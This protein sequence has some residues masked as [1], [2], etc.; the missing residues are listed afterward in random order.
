MNKKEF[1][2]HLSNT[3]YY[4][5]TFLILKTF[6]LLKLE[7]MGMEIGFNPS[8]LLSMHQNVSPSLVLENQMPLASING[9][10]LKGM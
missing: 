3:L 4:F 10:C 9:F 5:S 7:P 8:S 1:L 6:A 2:Y